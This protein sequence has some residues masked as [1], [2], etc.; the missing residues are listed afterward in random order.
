MWW[1]IAGVAAIFLASQNQAVADIVNDNVVAPLEESSAD[2]WKKYDEMFLHWGGEYGVD[3]NHLKAI[4]LNESNLGLVASVARGLSNP[5]DADGSQSSDGKSWGLMQV[6][7]S[8]GSQYDPSISPQKLNDP[9]YSISI[10]AHLF[11][12]NMNQFAIVDTRWLEWVVKSYNQGV[13]N[14]KKEIA[15]NGGGFA[16][17]YWDRWQRNY[18][19]IL[20]QGAIT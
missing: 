20:D 15:G 4:A 13:G 1:V 5:S 3:P 12:D 11:S 7:L 14:T 16:D 18:Q 9:D 10:A 17:A 19:K 6:T 8:T 2:N